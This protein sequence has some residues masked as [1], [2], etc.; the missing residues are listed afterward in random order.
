MRASIAILAAA[1]AASI[2]LALPARPSTAQDDSRDD[3]R[4]DLADDAPAGSTPAQADAGMGSTWLTQDE[5]ASGRHWRLRTDHG[6]VHVWTPPG[7]QAETAG[8]VAYVHGYYTNVDR[9]FAEHRLA[10]QF[11]ASG[12]NALFIVP[13]APAGSYESVHWDDLGVLI[14]TVRQ[15]IGVERPWGPVVAMGHSG[16]YRTLLTW[17]AYRPLEHVILVDALYGNESAFESWLGERDAMDTTTGGN[18][19]TMVSMDTLRWSEPWAHARG[20]ASTFDWVPDSAALPEDA[21][22]AKVLYIRSQYGHMELITDGKTI[23]VLLHAT[24]L[25]AL[26]AP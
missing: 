13:E 16:A 11:R 1:L 21:R 6:P 25:P 10:G 7:Y 26:S 8:V 14:R 12:K 17:L 15:R 24:A 3:N 23:P 9:A 2:L 18:R 19:L 4:D 5:L 22:T 20:F